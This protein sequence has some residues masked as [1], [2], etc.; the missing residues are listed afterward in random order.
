M[1]GLDGIYGTAPVASFKPNAPG[2][3]D[4]GW[5][6]RGNALPMELHARGL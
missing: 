1:M 2:V 6:G 3:Y 4:L 5:A